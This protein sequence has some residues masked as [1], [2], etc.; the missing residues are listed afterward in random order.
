MLNHLDKLK[1][2]KQN[3]HYVTPN[4]KGFNYLMLFMKIDK[5]NHCVLIDKKKIVIS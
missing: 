3:P 2:L 1:F 4:Y 5:I